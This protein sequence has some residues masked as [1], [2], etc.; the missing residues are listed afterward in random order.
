MELKALREEISAASFASPRIEQ[1]EQ[2]VSELAQKVHYLAL[3]LRPASLDDVGLLPSI[4]AFVEH[5]SARHGISADYQDAVQRNISLGQLIDANLYRI[6]QEALTNVAKH[7]QC[8]HV[9]VVAEKHHGHL[10]LLV[11]DNGCGF[12]VDEI[13]NGP[14]T[15]MRLGIDGMRERAGLAGGD[16]TIESEIGAGTT[17][18]AKIPCGN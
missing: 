9:S 14:F 13:I 17:V 16:L 6:V 1:L 18:I 4:A 3:E 7:S 5:W 8:S 11:E 2:L 15:D 12:G 10:I